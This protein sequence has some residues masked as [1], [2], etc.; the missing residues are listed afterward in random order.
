M[1]CATLVEPV[2]NSRIAQE[3]TAVVP[4]VDV[5]AADV[6]SLAAHCRRLERYYIGGI[7]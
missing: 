3:N 7:S 4:S 1:S 6:E 2:V 5:D